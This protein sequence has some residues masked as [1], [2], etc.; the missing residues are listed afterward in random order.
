LNP[1]SFDIGLAGVFVNFSRVTYCDHDAR[2][3]WN[4]T[5]CQGLGSFRVYY[6]SNESRRHVG[7]FVGYHS[8][9][10]MAV[11]AFRG[12]MYLVNWIEDLHYYKT[13]S[14]YTECENQTRGESEEEQI[15][16]DHRGSGFNSTLRKKCKVHSGFYNDWK[17]VRKDII[18]A[19]DQILADYPLAQVWVTGHSL[20][21]ALAALCALDLR[22]THLKDR[23]VGLYTFGE[24]RVGNPEFSDFFSEKL[25]TAYRLVHQDDIVPHLPPYGRDVLLLTNFHH[26]STEVWQS[27]GKDDKYY[28]CNGSGEDPKCSDSLPRWDRSVEAHRWYLQMHMSCDPDEKSQPRTDLEPLE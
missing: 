13:D 7:F 8:D 12:T 16:K 14:D 28:V 20:G 5:I 9:R 11:V 18:K 3:T 15:G 22:A 2:Q 6:N 24:P 4:C 1:T 26:H 23:E 17:S 25:P 10:N 27:G 19:L 21:G